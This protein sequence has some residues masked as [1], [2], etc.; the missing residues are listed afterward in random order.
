MPDAGVGSSPQPLRRATQA[1]PTVS[2]PHHSIARGASPERPCDRRAEA[3]P[4]R[5]R[6]LGSAAGP[7]ACL[8]GGENVLAELSDDLPNVGALGERPDPTAEPDQYRA[9]YP[10]QRGGKAPAIDRQAARAAA[11]PDDLVLRRP[12][13]PGDDAAEGWGA[14]RHQLASGRRG[15][16]AC[17]CDR[18]RREGEG[19]MKPTIERLK[20]LFRYDEETGKL[21]WIIKTQK[22]KAKPEKEAGYLTKYG[23]RVVGIDGKTYRVHNIIFVLHY[24]FWPTKT[25]DHINR[26]KNINIID[27][28]RDVDQSIQI[29]N[30]VLPNKSGFR[31]VIKVSNHRNLSKPYKVTIKITD[32]SK[33]IGYFATAQEAARAYDR[34]VI[35]NFG[36]DFPTNANLGLLD[37]VSAA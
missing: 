7:A 4:E 9:S 25:I 15:G 30:R 27:N 20:E 6:L 2:A 26:V 35:E 11:G 33:L 28:L 32:R 3:D 8:R 18:N 1:R 22:G 13:P 37:E 31:G 29:R 34:A 16:A 24:G 10:R 36:P 21:Y 17:T 23:Y 14:S 12:A 5:R 19:G